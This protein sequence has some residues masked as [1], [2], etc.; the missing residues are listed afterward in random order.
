M[1]KRKG[2]KKY[3]FVLTVIVFLCALIILP[4]CIVTKT[5]KA[6]RIGV[7]GDYIV[8]GSNAVT[9]GRKQTLLTEVALRAVK[10]AGRKENSGSLTSLTGEYRGN[11]YFFICKYYQENTGNKAPS[12]YSYF[13][14]EYAFGV[15]D[16]VGLKSRIYR[17]I[18]TLEDGAGSGIRNLSV[19][20]F[21]DTVVYTAESGSF[22][23]VK[24]NCLENT[25]VNLTV[26]N[27]YSLY[28]AYGNVFLFKDVGSGKFYAV[29]Y[30]TGETADTAGILEKAAEERLKEYNG[31][32][33]VCEVNDDFINID[34]YG[35]DGGFSVT[36]SEL[37]E[38]SEEFRRVEEIFGVEL[39]FGEVLILNGEIYLSARY[40]DTGMFGMAAYSNAS[41]VACFLYEPE[42]SEFKYI[43][44]LRANSVLENV[45]RL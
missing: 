23:I 16:I 6:K 28:Y 20:K 36:V 11:Y 39:T 38:K 37:R 26:E 19:D 3:R 13:K 21:G 40:L 32:K 15:I 34:E 22:E 41:T 30:I 42:L 24:S 9:R 2:L 18:E 31:K 17:I 12:G 10:K 45:I 14:T 7:Y 43:G 35:T 4:S 1:N 25:S 29:D 27:G 8:A 5:N 44:W 33:Y